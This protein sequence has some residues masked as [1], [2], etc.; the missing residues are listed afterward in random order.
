[1]ADNVNQDWGI[2]TNLLN[3]NKTDI[4]GPPSFCGALFTSWPRMLIA[5]IKFSSGP[6]EILRPQQGLRRTHMNLSQH[7]LLHC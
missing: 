7:Q 3:W 6:L 4:S 2:Y 5:P 1:M